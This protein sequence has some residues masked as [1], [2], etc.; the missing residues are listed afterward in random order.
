MGGNEPNDIIT[1][2][3]K[4]VG[5]NDIKSESNEA[6]E[7]LSARLAKAGG[8]DIEKIKKAYNVA[9]SLH[10]GQLRKSGAPYI[11]HPIAVAEIVA[12][13]KLDTDAIFAA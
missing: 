13:L 2:C 11:T 12:D 4:I 3:E 1:D 8:Y 5:V 9:N 6:F 7:N 10:E